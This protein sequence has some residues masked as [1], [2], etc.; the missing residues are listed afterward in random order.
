M[1]ENN[2]HRFRMKI[3]FRKLNLLALREVG[4]TFFINPKR[5]L[6]V[7]CPVYTTLC[8]WQKMTACVDTKDNVGRI[9]KELMKPKKMV[10]SIFV[11]FNM[12]TALKGS[13]F[14]FLFVVSQMFSQTSPIISLWK[15]HA[16]WVWVVW[17]SGALF[18]GFL[19]GL[20]AITTHKM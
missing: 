14:L 6:N 13:Q 8:M 5:S 15:K 10:W 3:C 11:L 1:S 17:T 19:N 12:L 16:G 20:L 2:P 7:Q 4:A 18:A 9:N